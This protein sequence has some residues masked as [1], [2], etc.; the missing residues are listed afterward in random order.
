MARD[1]LLIGVPANGARASNALGPIRWSPG[2]LSL[3]LNGFSRE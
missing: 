1:A 3:L 2:S